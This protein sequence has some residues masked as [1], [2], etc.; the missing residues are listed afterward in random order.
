MSLSSTIHWLILIF[1]CLLSL[2]PI[3]KGQPSVGATISGTVRCGG[4]CDTVGLKYGD[5]V[6]SGGTVEAQM[7]TAL[8]PFTGQPEPDLP[9]AS[10]STT[11]ATID[12]N[13]HYELQVPF[14][15]FD[16]YA[17]A[18]GYQTTLFASGVVVNK[19]GQS[20]A[21]DAYVTVVPTPASAYVVIV[22]VWAIIVSNVGFVLLRRYPRKKRLII[23]SS[24]IVVVSGSVIT[25]Y[26]QGVLAFF[27]GN[28]PFLLTILIG[29][30]NLPYLN[31]KAAQI[32][33][34][35]N[36][37]E[38]NSMLLDVSQS[39]S[40]DMR[41][42]LDSRSDSVTKVCQGRIPFEVY[43]RSERE[44]TIWSVWIDVFPA[45]PYKVSSLTILRHTIFRYVSRRRLICQ[46]SYTLNLDSSQGVPLQVESR[47]VK[48]LWVDALSLLEAIPHSNSNYW[49]C[50]TLKHSG[51]DKTSKP[52]PLSCLRVLGLTPKLN[53][54]F[55]S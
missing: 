43:N 26:S 1:V 23:S 39:S 37:F 17:S 27:E 32:S 5:P 54:W 2:N 41:S 50:L 25:I 55:E 47:R 21:F 36:P 12:E 10:T 34:R 35:Q 45:F 53:H 15:I 48:L 51:G 24:V 42:M 13:G 18:N 40:S 44:L 31:S 9:L 49:F 8:D 3:A 19:T 29:I 30:I 11:S 14:G 33:E 16:L 4:G 52:F 7:T 38:I 20:F 46:A 28:F 6:R 22:V